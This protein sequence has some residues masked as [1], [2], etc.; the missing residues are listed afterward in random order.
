MQP[1]EIEGRKVEVPA[2][3][4]GLETFLWTSDEGRGV[5]ESGRNQGQAR[6]HRLPKPILVSV[7][8]RLGLLVSASDV[9][10]S[11]G[12]ESESE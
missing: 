4:E 8:L 12:T 1:T 5:S 9:G 10:L 3:P 6:P 7:S 11:S 2:S